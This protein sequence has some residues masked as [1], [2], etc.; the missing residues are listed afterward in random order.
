LDINVL[1]WN[2]GTGG[3]TYGAAAGT[4][5]DTEILFNNVG[6]VGGDSGMT[7]T[8]ATQTATFLNIIV[9]GSLTLINST[10]IAL[11][12]SAGI[13]TQGAD[14]VAIGNSA[15]SISQG[16]YAV[17]IGGGAGCNRQGTGGVAIGYGAAN[18]SQGV[19]AIAIGAYAGYTSQGGGGIAIGNTA[20]NISQGEGAVAIGSIAGE[21]SQGSNAVAIGYS[22]GNSSQGA[23]AV[24]IGSLAGDSSQGFYAVAIGHLAG[25]LKQGDSAIAIGHTAAST[26][27]GLYAVAIGNGAGNENQG[28]SAVA[29]GYGAANIS[30][31]GGAVAIGSNAG[32]STQGSNAIAIGNNAGTNSQ[33]S[34]S[35][36]LNATGSFLETTVSGFFVS[37]VRQ[38]TG[39]YVMA[40]NTTTNEISYTT[41]V[42]SDKRLKKDISDTQLGLSFI[43]QLRPVQFKW[44]DRNTFGLDRSGNCLPITAP[45]VRVHQGL[46]AQEVK[47]VFDSMGIDSAI[48]ISISSPPITRTTIVRDV[49]GNISTSNI[50]EI[51]P[52]DGVQGIRYE[53]LISPIIQS[54]K[55]MYVLLQ[56][57]AAKI[58]VLEQTISSL[59]SSR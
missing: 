46:I 47:T 13:T 49:C 53:E 31:G 33:S 16:F 22:A 50:I 37:P 8:S 23:D 5:S 34:N 19:T 6:A 18:T 59:V 39:D 12:I 21:L 56:K 52:L 30:Q 29:I 24:A 45:G 27:Q 7:F 2:A 44:A 32:N 35:I 26:S 40:Y 20:A 42:S 55:D 11:G 10:T 48:Y 57:Q 58:E 54:V 36:I 4:S 51:N 43:N 38:Q 17:A 25:H 3:I 1:F 41:E 15:A 9:N 14:A 28:P